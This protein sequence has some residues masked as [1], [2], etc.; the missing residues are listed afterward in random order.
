MPIVLGYYTRQSSRSARSSD[1]KG[2]DS[3]TLVARSSATDRRWL[4]HGSSI[5][6]STSLHL[7]PQFLAS[8]TGVTALA[9]LQIW[10]MFIRTIL[11]HLYSHLARLSKLFYVHPGGKSQL[12]QPPRPP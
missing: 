4:K 7:L 2:L 1:T 12:T 10:Q 3:W 9:V 11:T 5:G 8:Q 6:K